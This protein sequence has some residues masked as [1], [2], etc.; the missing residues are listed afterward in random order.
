MLY[1]AQYGAEWHILRS[2]TPSGEA[3][4]TTSHKKVALIGRFELA[5]ASG[6]AASTA[7]AAAA[8][9]PSAIRRL[10]DRREMVQIW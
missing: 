2:H 10:S 4:L 8:S 7:A 6:A 9:K 3:G 5:T 1:G